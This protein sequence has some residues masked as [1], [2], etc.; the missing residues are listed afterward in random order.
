MKTGVYPGRGPLPDWNNPEL[1][2]SHG[3]PSHANMV[4]YP[5][6]A[7][8]QHA[9]SNNR[10]YL[11]PYVMMLSDGWESRFYA[12]ILQLPESIL[13][14]RSGFEPA[15]LPI[16]MPKEGCKSFPI[17]PPH[18][19]PMQPVLVLRRTCR[20]PLGWGSTKKKIVLQGIRSACHVYVNSRLAGYC[21]G[22][23]LPA[24]FEITNSLHDADNEIFLLI[25]ATS[26]ASYLEDQSQDLLPG[27]IRDIWLEAVPTISI[28]DVQ[29]QTQRQPDGCWKLDLDISVLSYRIST[30]SPKLK[31]CLLAGNDS[32]HFSEHYIELGSDGVDAFGPPAQAVG[33]LK[34][35][36][37]LEDVS[38][39]SDEM[40]SLYDLYVS[41]EERGGQE[42]CCVH[43]TVGFREIRLEQGRVL[44][45][46]RPIQIRGLVW[47]AQ[48]DSVVN[49]KHLHNMVK[50]LKLMKKSHLNTLYFKDVP[51]DP[52]FLE[53]CD[54]FGIYVIDEAPL[55][56]CHPT[57]AHA[58][59][60]DDC[61]MK[62]SQHRLTRLVRRDNNHP[63]VLMWSAGLFRQ[64]TAIANLLCRHLRTL[65]ATRPH[66]L[67]DTPDILSFLNNIDCGSAD[68]DWFATTTSDL[69][70]L[71][72]R[73]LEQLFKPLEI[74][75]VD[76]N[77]G[78]FSIQNNMNYLTSSRYLIDW[79]VL[80][81]GRVMMAG[82]LANHP[83][84]PG[85]RQMIELSLDRL[86][87][88]DAVEYRL[89]FEISYAKS[90]MWADCGQ[91]AFFTEFILADAARQPENFP[92]KSQGRLRLEA[93]R[94]Q[95]IVSGSRFW[96]VFN[97]LNGSLE[98]WRM[99][100]HELIL[101]SQS[102]AH[103][104]RSGLNATLWRQPDLFDR[105]LVPDWLEAGYDRLIPQVLSVQD[106]CDGQEAAIEMLVLLAPQGRPAAF[107]RIIRY[108]VSANG[109]L[110]LFTSLRKLDQNLPPIPASGLILNLNND[111]D[112]VSW[113]GCGPNC[114]FYNLNDSLRR[115]VYSLMMRDDNRGGCLLDD[116][117]GLFTD[118]SQLC[119]ATPDS[120][121]LVVTSGLPFGFSIKPVI[122]Q[123]IWP[124][125][126]GST[127]DIKTPLL[128]LFGPAA[129]PSAD[130]PVRMT[131]QFTPAQ[132]AELELLT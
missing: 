66:H 52:I 85:E 69:D 47:P 84:K 31:I 115:G 42:I 94:H 56:L 26:T 46:D 74:T 77:N 6:Q 48:A 132:P 28:Q 38:P 99:G 103:T 105:Q 13:S 23:G 120:S 51:V 112:Q 129:Q 80:K 89:R 116:Q 9:L 14:F 131:W 16:Q 82:D 20:L 117:P 63:S 12:N 125:K 62:A 17:T 8:C 32:C 50:T 76:L 79:M 30:E 130:H 54:L 75:A 61:W 92:T 95:L 122:R 29:Y 7:T 67:M 110:S 87:Q 72:S 127:A 64:N 15:K 40:P 57:V 91:S 3:L 34:T 36:V 86:V 104:G 111:Y 109:S 68:C 58:F 128:L 106:G 107:E 98:S 10:R 19:P 39:W 2:A 121:G 113:F 101:A 83:I 4:L 5:E 102:D 35:S 25:Y 70:E 88:D 65:D 43:Q 11:S 114:G 24:E 49:S 45:N 124:G 71:L 37:L 96:M 44:V 18:I 108:N 21:E 1:M 73:E 33:R 119:L 97:R 41:V 123:G 81:N 59:D 22:T 90:E 118:T 55:A 53:L 126:T 93:D 60:L 27:L 78:I 100:D